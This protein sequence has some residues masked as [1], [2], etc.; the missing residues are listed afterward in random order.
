MATMNYT[1]ELHR[2]G[3]NGAPGTRLS[4]MITAADLGQAKRQA[5]E[6]AITETATMVSGAV[7]LALYQSDCVA[8]KRQIA[9]SF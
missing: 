7:H 6:W 8:W 1:A 2:S 9:K 3:E 4:R 5:Q